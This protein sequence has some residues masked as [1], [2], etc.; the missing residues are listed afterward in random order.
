MR[1]GIIPRPAEDCAGE[2]IAR[3]NQSARPHGQGAMST[4]AH[5][6]RMPGQAPHLLLVYD[7]AVHVSDLKDYGKQGIAAYTVGKRGRSR[8]GTFA[9]RLE[10]MR[11]VI[12]GRA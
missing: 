10:A 6:S 5:A 11:A 3:H 7:S 12:W 4:L 2:Y 9:N 1:S 8:I